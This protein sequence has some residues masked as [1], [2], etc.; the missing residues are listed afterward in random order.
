MTAPSV[1]FDTITPHELRA[2]IKRLKTLP[3][4]PRIKARVVTALEDPDADFETVAAMIELDQSLTSQILRLANSAFY[5]VQGSISDVTQ[6]LVMLGAAV[7][8]SLV[9]SSTVF[10]LQRV[11][12][13]GFWEHSLGCA[14]AS[15]AIS[16]VTG[17]GA[18]EEVTAAGLMHDLGIVVLCR[19]LPD[20]LAHISTR[21]LEEKRPFREVELEVLGLDHGELG[22]LAER[23]N[24]PP[25]LAEPIMFHHTPEKAVAAADEVAIVHVANSLVH[26]LGYGSAGDTS[27]PA[28]DDDAWKR[29][30][31]D[32]ER[33]DRVLETFTEDLDHALNY[34]ILG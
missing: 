5:G 29:L 15:G 17:I 32:A 3:T 23:W 28:I 9:L 34:A 2:R 26:G 13:E 11:P 7:S 33:L 21:A 31:L 4:L 19:E 24:F 30:G 14:V 6:A 18:P 1:S 20:A 22:G 16:K 12:V 10:D 27:V 8:R 25:C